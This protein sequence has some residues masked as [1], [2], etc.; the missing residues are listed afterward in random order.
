[1]RWYGV[2]TSLSIFW[3]FYWAHP[4]PVLLTL[5][6]IGEEFNFSIFWLVNSIIKF[7][8]NNIWYVINVEDE[9]IVIWIDDQHILII[10][11]ILW[12]LALEFSVYLLLLLLFYHS[13]NFLKYFLWFNCSMEY[14]YPFL[15]LHAMACFLVISYQ[16]YLVFQLVSVYMLYL[17]W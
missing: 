4:H 2:D 14:L 6:L 15:S 12:V 9:T 17:V 1:M 13:V 10:L 5:F 11:I 3:Q 16:F 8:L 7:M